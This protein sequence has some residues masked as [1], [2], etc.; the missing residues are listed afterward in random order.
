LHFLYH[1]E[2]GFRKPNITLRLWFG[3]ILLQKTFLLVFEKKQ[4]VF[5]FV[6]NF[7]FVT[8]ISNKMVKT[9]THTHSLKHTFNI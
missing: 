5:C 3:F 2:F 9:H 6:S 4:K 8:D 1:D 7:D